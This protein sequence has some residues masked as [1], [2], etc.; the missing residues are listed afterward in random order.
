MFVAVKAASKPT[1]KILNNSSIQIK[2]MLNYG[3]YII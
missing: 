1:W 3:M 2:Y